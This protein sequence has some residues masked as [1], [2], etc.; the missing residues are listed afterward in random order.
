[1]V[2]TCVRAGDIAAAIGRGL[3][4]PVVALS[5]E[6]AERHFGWLAMF[7]GLDM[8]ATSAW[9]RKRLDWHPTGPGLIADLEAMDYGVV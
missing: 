3:R 5:P 1:M 2:K 8:P 7:V 6:E 9:T 4:V